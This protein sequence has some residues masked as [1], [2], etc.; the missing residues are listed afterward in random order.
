MGKRPRRDSDSSSD[1]EATNSD[2]MRSMSPPTSEGSV[3]PEKYAQ[4]DHATQANEPMRC[5]LPPHKPL[6]FS[7]YEEYDVHYQQTHV[8]RCLECRKNFPSNHYLNVH[9]AE[10]H[11]PLNEARRAR[12]EKTVCYL[13]IVNLCCSSAFFSSMLTSAWIVRLLRGGLRALLFHT[14]ETSLACH[15]QASIS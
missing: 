3:H 7:S 13:K 9:I 8:N 4:V 6:S 5:F 2:V 10:N 12:G 11:D 1:L 14:T 15:R